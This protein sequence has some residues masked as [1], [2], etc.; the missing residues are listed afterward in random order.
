M[1]IHPIKKIATAS[2][3]A[4]AKFP[5]A[6]CTP[7]LDCTDGDLITNVTIGTINNTSTCGANGYSGLYSHN[8]E[9]SSRPNLSDSVTVGTGW[10]YENVFSLD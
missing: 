6:Y 4:P 8:N 7:A 10:A 1:A 3:L 9:C 5:L 2:T